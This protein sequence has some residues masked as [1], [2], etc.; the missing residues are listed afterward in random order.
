MTGW[1]GLSL[2][3]IVSDNAG[4]RELMGVTN[5]QATVKKATS[6]LDVV[7]VAAIAGT[8]GAALFKIAKQF[9]LM[10]AKVLEPLY[11]VV[12]PEAARLAGV[13]RYRDLRRFSTQMGML[14]AAVAAVPLAAFLLA[15]W[16]TIDLTV[17]REFRPAVVAIACYLG[18]SVLAHGTLGASRVLLVTDRPR[19]W[20]AVTVP[21][22]L[23]YLGALA[24]TAQAAGVTGASVAY[25]VHNL[26]VLGGL[27]IAAHHVLRMA[28][29]DTHL[30]PDLQPEQ[31]PA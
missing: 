9:G 5:A 13:G 11:Q 1:L 31:R 24:P 23:V 15:P 12:L 30:Q 27:L 3:G 18:A 22:A 14:G 4:I 25:L 26:F 20:L 2:R 7:V 8:E 21:P 16:V 10:S 28:E 6:E 19:Y 17:G 29:R